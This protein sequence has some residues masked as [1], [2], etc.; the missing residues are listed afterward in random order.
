MSN[1]HEPNTVCAVCSTPLYR[2]PMQISKNKSGL[3]FC[4]MKHLG[5]GIKDETLPITTG[6]RR[7]KG[8]AVKPPRYFSCKS[9]GTHQ[10]ETHKNKTYCNDV[11]KEAYISALV[12]KECK[13]CKRILPISEFHTAKTTA[14][15][16]SAHCKNCVLDRWKNWYTND[17]ELKRIKNTTRN[18]EYNKTDKGQ[19]NALRK[20][21]GQYGLTLE[22]YAA[23]IERSKGCC[24][25]CGEEDAY[26]IDHDHST[27]LVRGLLC[28][29]CNIA[30][31]TF[32]DDRSRLVKAIQ[33]LDTFGS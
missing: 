28:N 23:L 2:T 19:E 31:G 15:R 14:D 25:L 27:G 12:E 26:A 3:F 18:H 24:E 22:E 20:R 8:T 30:L 16:H 6:P 13:T 9:C 10:K 4:S 32:K 21:I 5:V 7:A 33:Y 17:I 1:K 29:P 11:C